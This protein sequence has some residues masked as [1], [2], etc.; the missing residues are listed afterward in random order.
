M[1][2][3]SAH[4]ADMVLASLFDAALLCLAMPLES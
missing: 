2:G 4:A 3:Q 1:L